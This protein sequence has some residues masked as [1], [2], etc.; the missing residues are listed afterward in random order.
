MSETF[1]LSG[2]LGRYYVHGNEGDDTFWAGPTTSEDHFY[3]GAGNDTFYG[4]QE[5]DYFDGDEGDDRLL[6]ADGSDYLVANKGSDLLIGGLGGDNFHIQDCTQATLA[7]FTASDGDRLILDLIST[8]NFAAASGE[9]EL[10]NLIDAGEANFIYEENTRVA[11]WREDDQDIYHKI[12]FDSPVSSADLKL[13]V[14][15]RDEVLQDPDSNVDPVTRSSAALIADFLDGRERLFAGNPIDAL[16]L[17][18]DPQLA[19]RWFYN[20][21]LI[22]G[23]NAA[24]YSDEV[25]EK[26]PSGSYIRETVYTDGAGRRQM[27]ASDPLQVEPTREDS[28]LRV[29][30]IRLDPLQLTSLESIQPGLQPLPELLQL[31]LPVGD[32]SNRPSTLPGVQRIEL[33]PTG[34]ATGYTGLVALI[35]PVA[36]LDPNQDGPAAR[37]PAESRQGGAG[38]YDFDSD[39]LLDTLTWQPQPSGTSSPTLNTSLLSGTIS[40]LAALPDGTLR[41][42]L[43]DQDGT[44]QPLKQPA[45]QCLSL[46][47]LEPPAPAQTGSVMAIGLNEGETLEGLSADQRRQRAIHLISNQD[48]TPAPLESYADLYRQ[49][50]VRADQRM[51][52][53]EVPGRNANNWDGSLLSEPLKVVAPSQ[54]PWAEP[55]PD[56]PGPTLE[57]ASASGLRLGLLAES[58]PVDL[59]GFVARSQASAPVLDFRGLEELTLDITLEVAREAGFDSQMSFYAIEDPE[60]SVQDPISGELVKPGDADYARLAQFHRVE[61]LSDLTT[62]N[63]QSTSKDLLLRESRLLAPMAVVKDPTQGQQIY[64]AFA[65]ANSDH[66]GHFLNFGNGVIGL[67]DSPNL[68]FDFDDNMVSIQIRPLGY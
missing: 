61:A 26:L 63:L 65:G 20:G 35:D 33:T 6:G 42:L 41:F 13:S 54:D 22:A 31:R 36:L 17:A 34:A 9:D 14:F 55:L 8:I 24:S 47:L 46:V 66:I 38:V 37:P 25:L 19:Y 60:G 7:D 1:D 67:E 21:Y 62:E 57:L 56:S 2:G 58:V 11:Q 29:L 53:F 49:L 64:Y 4:G 50:W 39:G 45:L 32:S 15:G 44:P 12:S 59:N 28:G 23:A 52:L 27:V 3:G 18:A 40:T 48:D 10:R 43:N 16:G 51:V 68:D 30:R 5:N